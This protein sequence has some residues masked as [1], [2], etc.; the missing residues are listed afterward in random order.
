MEVELTNYQHHHA[1][2][3]PNELLEELKLE[4]KKLLKWNDKVIDWLT[5]HVLAS[6][7]M[8]NS[9]FILP[10]FVLPLP[11]W[12]KLILAVI[13]SNWIQWWALPALQR[14]A[15]KIQALQDAKAEVDHR[16]LTHIAHTLDEQTKLLKE[17][18]AKAKG[19]GCIGL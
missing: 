17:I 18:H 15:N 16:A 7:I 1:V 12:T 8:F 10:L 3:H 6:R 4:E 11:E 2:K 5:D 9:A 14:R 19:G 13:S